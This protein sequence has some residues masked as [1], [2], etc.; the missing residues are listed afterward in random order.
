MADIFFLFTHY[1]HRPR[2]PLLM[3]EMCHILCDVSDDDP[4]R[5]YSAISITPTGPT[6][7]KR[8]VRRYL[9]RCCTHT[10][11]C[12]LVPAR[13][14]DGNPHGLR[15]CTPSGAAKNHGYD[16]FCVASGAQANQRRV[17]SS[18]GRFQDKIDQNR[19][20]RAHLDTR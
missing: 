6:A 3:Q 5:S 15:D 12:W 8:L 18:G 19:P 7:I 17:L 9:F 14:G 10:S 1:H 20:D 13:P 11:S 4:I 16:H 2:L